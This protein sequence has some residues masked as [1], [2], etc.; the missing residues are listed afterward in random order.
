M[1]VLWHS[2]ASWIP[3]GYGNQTA[4]FTPRLRGAGHDVVVSAFCGLEM[5]RMYDGAG[6]LHLARGIDMHGNDAIEGHFYRP[7]WPNHQAGELVISLIDP[8]VL[9]PGNWGR[10]PWAAWTPIDSVPAFGGNIK[11]LRHARWVW[12]MSQFGHQQLVNAGLNPIY[13]PHGIETN[14]YRPADRDVARARLS[15]YLETNL[16]DKYLVVSVAANK[17][18]PSRKNFVGMI[19]SFALFVR[20]NEALGLP[21]HPDAMLYIHTEKQGVYHGENIGE[22]ARNFGVADRVLLPHQYDMVM[23]MLG[24]DFLND[25]YNAADVFLLLSSEGFGIPTVEAQ[26]AGC[27]VVVADFAASSELCFG[28]WKV[29]GMRRFNPTTGTHWYEVI[30]PEAARVLCEAYERRGDDSLRLQ[31]RQGAREYDADRVF[32]QYMLP[33]VKRMARDLIIENTRPYHVAEAANV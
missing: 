19:E 12:S 14:V 29:T 3:T 23:S 21:A 4:L 1:N 31:A 24:P 16:T 5:A 17:G 33:A 7:H 13:V 8:F 27:P 11:A 28:G 10:L 30:V 18:T 32:Q 22:I 6:I 15:V 20:G 2:N 26:S 9:N 25:V